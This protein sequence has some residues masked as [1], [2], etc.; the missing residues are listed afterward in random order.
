MGGR[1]RRTKTQREKS[2]DN[3][4]KEERRKTENNPKSVSK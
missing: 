3:S 4:G 1:K 2:F